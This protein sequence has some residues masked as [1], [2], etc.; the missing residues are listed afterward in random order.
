MLAYILL[1]VSVL[2]LLLSVC[3]AGFA[4]EMQ[5]YTENLSGLKYDQF[6]DICL[7]AGYDIVYHVLNGDA[8]QAQLVSDR[9]NAAFR[10]TDAQGSLHWQ[11]DDYES[12][13]AGLAYLYDFVFEA[14]MEDGHVTSL[15]LRRVEGGK[16]ELGE[17]E[18]AVS[19]KADPAHGLHDS[20]YWRDRGLSILYGLRYAVYAIGALSLGLAVI[21]FV[22]L[23]CGAGH[24]QGI[25]E[26]VPGYLYKV[27]FDVL[28]VAILGLVLLMVY[29]LVGRRYP[30]DARILTL[31]G[32][33]AV[34]GVPL[35]TGWCVS[36]AARVKLGKW[37]KNTVVWRVLH[38]LW[39]CLRAV[40]RL[41]RGLPLVWK[42]ALALFGIALLEFLGIVGV[43][44]DPER[45]LLLWAMEKL[46]LGAA[47]LWIA[48]TL[49]RLQKAGEALA[50]GDLN[51][52][53]DT[54][55]MFWS[56]RL[57]GENLN[58]A[59][60]GMRRAVDEQM[61][62][63][64]FKTE[65]IT[66]VSHDIKTP[67][68]SIIS[69]VDL[70]RRGA[71]ETQT[72]EYLD[73]LARQSARL[74]KLTE[75]LVE[76]SKASTGSVEVHLERRSVSE[77]LRQATGEYAE[78]LSASGIETVTRLPEYEL[79]AWAD[80]ALLWRVLDNLLSNVCKYAQSGT[81]FYIGVRSEN[82]KAVMEFK[83]TSREAL[84]LSAEELM[85]R[86]VRGDSARTGEGSGLGLS[87]A[88]SLT[89]LQGGTFDLS[90]DGDLFKVTITLPIV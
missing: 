73:V 25:E 32:L 39:R 24:R 76:M 90:V 85:E 14:Q 54:R 51:Y 6:R 74:K 16:P 2:T 44:Y 36:L 35:L 81:R 79:I 34:A 80:G 68:T 53:T 52:R 61:K 45:L 8:R 83:N 63:E 47:V 75:D 77:L 57:H 20:L 7:S 12:F 11:S 86:F 64:R 43:H 27:P 26:L 1:T 30:S 60:L 71:D 22:F 72:K 37:W 18:F 69:Y 40:G 56:F 13:D 62:S 42:T 84:N 15:I 23:L 78:R 33:L 5:A 65:L 4:W 29:L 88:R 21:C 17:N 3:G 10:M 89:E 70:L 41:L 50:A 55:H 87:I 82:G 49:R 38:L 67:L 58:S 31:A 19:A 59:A 48:L 66:N 9:M 28:T 46:V